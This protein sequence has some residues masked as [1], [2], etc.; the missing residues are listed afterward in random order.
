MTERDLNGAAYGRRLIILMLAAAP[1]IAEAAEA[2]DGGP[3]PRLRQKRRNRPQPPAISA[4]P[5]TIKY[6][7]RSR[8]IRVL[9]PRRC[10]PPAPY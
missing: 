10:C 8:F 1:E 9:F 2:S 6:W 7:R 4:A 5:S 3:L